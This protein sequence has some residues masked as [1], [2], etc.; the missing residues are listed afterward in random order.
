MQ[1]NSNPPGGMPAQSARTRKL[2]P[3]H[4]LADDCG[5]ALRY[6]RTATRVK[7]KASHASV[8]TDEIR[9]TTE[10]RGR[11]W[12]SA[13]CELAQAI[14]NLVFPPRCAA[15]GCEMEPPVPSPLLCV[16]CCQRLTASNR[17]ACPICASACSEVD[18]A[19]GD[20]SRCR[21]RKLS[22]AASRAI[23][24]YEGELRQAVLRAKHAA[25]EPLASALG[26]NLAT[27]ILQTPFSQPP[28]AVTA[29]PMHWLKR[30]WRKTNPAETLAR[31]ASQQLGLPFLRRALT[32]VRYL[33]RQATLTPADPRRN[34]RGAFRALNHATIRG[35]RLLL[36]DDV[37]TTGATAEE[38]SNALM[39][40]G[41]ASVVVATIARASPDF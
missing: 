34:V 5:E 16:T 12:A 23:G 20:C 10:H 33:R 29:V 24:N 40:A 41:A 21:N 7:T 15:C 8:A 32:C 17:V 13:G 6:D 2:S 38:C 27:Y 31:T 18:L 1:S 35:K 9:M 11:H 22:F 37:M 4:R 19:R 26:T 28:Q 3:A 30:A 14:I 39:E 36:I 25:Y